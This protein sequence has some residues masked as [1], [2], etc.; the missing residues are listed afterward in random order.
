VLGWLAAQRGAAMSLEVNPW[1][2]VY[3]V[4]KVARGIAHVGTDR[5]L[6]GRHFGA[7]LGAGVGSRSVP[8][9]GGVW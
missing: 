9:L 6:G 4:S 1:L 2:M 5:G 7:G 3:S 8:C